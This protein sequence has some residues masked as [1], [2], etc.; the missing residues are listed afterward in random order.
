MI[1]RL[2]CWLADWLSDSQWLREMHRAEVMA[3]RSAARHE[4][5]AS[6]DFAQTLDVAPWWQRRGGPP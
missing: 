4:R 1:R 2:L 3:N 5:R 6:R